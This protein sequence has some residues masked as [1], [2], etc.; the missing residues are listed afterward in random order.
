MSIVVCLVIL[1]VSLTNYVLKFI[2]L[3]GNRSHMPIHVYHTMRNALCVFSVLIHTTTLI[4]V[5]LWL[6]CIYGI[7]I[8]EFCGGTLFT[9][10][11]IKFWHIITNWLRTMKG[12]YLFG[13]IL[14]PCLCVRMTPWYKHRTCHCNIILNDELYHFGAAY[15]KWLNLWYVQPG[16][17]PPWFNTL[18]LRQNGCHFPDDVFKCIFLNENI[19]ISLKISLKFIPKVRINNIPAFGSDNG[20]TPTR[21][22]AII[23]TNGG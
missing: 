11:R 18:R 16:L 14:W 1:L 15:L 12:T 23:W 6:E 13:F 20:L 22:Q 7:C 9:R 17:I 3:Y 21:R 5:K 19:W 2:F 10:L 4:V 8:R